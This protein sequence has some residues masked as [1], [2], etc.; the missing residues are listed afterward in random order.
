MIEGERMR[1]GT[2]TLVAAATLLAGCGDGV[3]GSPVAAERWDPCSI[4]RE[5]VASTGLD[6]S[7]R[8]EGWGNGIDVPEWGRCVFQA[9]GGSSSPYALDVVSSAEHTID[10]SRANPS[11][12][13]GRDI[14]IR[15][16]EGYM[17]VTEFGAAIRDC[18]IALEVAGGVVVFTALYRIDD[19]VDAC[20]VVRT[21]V[22]DLEIFVPA[23]PK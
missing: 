8:A 22:S 5:A 17:F 2:A 16:R 18:Q 3:E 15:G 6:P 20:D 1:K 13:E 14:E 23:A 19:G 7:R 12:R 10:E 11:H 4:T 9:P 21:H